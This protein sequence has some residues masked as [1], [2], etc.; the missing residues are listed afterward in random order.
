MAKSKKKPQESPTSF[1]ETHE[2]TELWT[3]GM[4]I[5]TGS[6]GIVNLNYLTTDGADR[7]IAKGFKLIRR[8][9]EEG[10]DSSEN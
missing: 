3:G 2:V 10:N 8:K 7:L 4:K 1:S 5:M 6:Y 9:A